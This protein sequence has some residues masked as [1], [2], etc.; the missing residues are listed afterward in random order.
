MGIRE[1]PCYRRR[2]CTPSV[3]HSTIPA[4]ATT[5]SNRYPRK[6]TKYSDRCAA[7][8]FSFRPMVQS[9][10]GAFAPLCS[11]TW[12]ELVRGMAAHRGGP[13][14]SSLVEEIHQGPSHAF[15]FHQ[16][17]HMLHATLALVWQVAAKNISST[18]RTWLRCT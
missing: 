5:L 6:E 17:M 10:W 2:N 1:R 3:D 15:T 8:G 9:T 4:A 18:R 11:E 16:G 13:A 14:R 12:T 7:A